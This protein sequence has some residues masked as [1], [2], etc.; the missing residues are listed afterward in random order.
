G[1]DFDLKREGRTGSET[2]FHTRSGS[3]QDPVP[4]M[5]RCHTYRIRQW[6]HRVRDPVPPMTRCTPTGSDS[7]R[8]GSEIRFHTRPGSTH[9]PMPHLPDQTVVAPGQRPG[10]THDPM[11]TYRIRQ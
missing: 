3:T 5:T 9:D 10:S 11:H 8:T 4:P 1:R 6:S 2:R 7:G